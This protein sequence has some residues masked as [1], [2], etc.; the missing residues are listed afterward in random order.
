MV[1]SPRWFVE[2][3]PGVF[4]G[5]VNSRISNLLW[6]RFSN[7]GS[8]RGGI[9]IET[10]KTEQRYRLFMYG[11]P[12][13]EVVDYEGVQLIK[14]IDNRQEEDPYNDTVLQDI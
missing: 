2:I 9:R 8:S 14:R 12:Y 5:K 4:V 6:E 1:N 11:T 10:A 7:E 3:K 13:R